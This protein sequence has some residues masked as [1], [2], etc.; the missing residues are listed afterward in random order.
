MEKRALMWTKPTAIQMG[1]LNGNSLKKYPSLNGLA[2][3]PRMTE[4]R[5][6]H[7]RTTVEVLASL[8]NMRSWTGMF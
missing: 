6:S 2:N 4:V 7:H 8:Q 1:T 3:H 5:G